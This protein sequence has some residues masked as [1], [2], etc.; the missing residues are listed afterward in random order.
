[1]WYGHRAGP[2]KHARGPCQGLPCAALCVCVCVCVP[3]QV[4]RG[5]VVETL[6]GVR[7]AD[8]YR[9]LE[10]PDSE[11]TRECECVCVQGWVVITSLNLNEL[12]GRQ[13]GG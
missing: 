6:H 7:V 9:W 1:M 12:G 8:P 13:A 4:R 2:A 3:P 5:E 10:D 11:D